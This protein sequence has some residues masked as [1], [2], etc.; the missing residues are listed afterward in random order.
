[1]VFEVLLHGDVER[2]GRDPGIRIAPRFEVAVHP[3]GRPEDRAD[4]S[5]VFAFERGPLR[6]GAAE[7]VA[8]VGERRERE[9]I[10]TTEGLLQLGRPGEQPLDPGAVGRRLHR[11]EPFTAEIARCVGAE[12]AT[13]GI[14][15]ELLFCVC[16]VELHQSGFGGGTFQ[17]TLERTARRRIPHGAPKNARNRTERYASTGPAVAWSPMLSG[18]DTCRTVACCPMMESSREESAMRASAKTIVF[19]STEP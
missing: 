10:A 16:G 17:T 5:E 15:A 1:V 18:L 6:P 13:D 2:K 9:R 3:P 19:L 12:P 14:E 8:D 11:V 7:G 4:V